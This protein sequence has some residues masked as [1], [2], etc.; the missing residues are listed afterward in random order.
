M[1]E[2]P[3][4]DGYIDDGTIKHPLDWNTK[5]LIDHLELL[6]KYC[7]QYKFL[8]HPEKFILLQQM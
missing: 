1:Y 2:N 5:Q 3:F 8:L 4:Y 6:F 7:D